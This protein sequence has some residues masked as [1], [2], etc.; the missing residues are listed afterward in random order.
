LIHGRETKGVIQLLN[1]LNDEPFTTVHQELLSDIAPSLALALDNANLYGGLNERLSELAAIQKITEAINS[2]TDIASL[3][4]RVA[5]E[6]QILIGANMTNIYQY[7][8]E[9]GEFFLQMEDNERYS[10][11]KPGGRSERILKEGQ[12]IF[13]DDVSNH[14]ILKESEFRKQHNIKAT[15]VAPLRAGDESVGL[16]FLNFE[17]QRVFS[18]DEKRIIA[19]IA[20]QAATAIQTVGRLNDTNRQLKTVL[21]S[22]EAAGNSKSLEELLNTYLAFSLREVGA[23]NGT[24][25][26]I[27]ASHGAGLCLA[28]R[29]Y[30][31]KL[32]ET[33]KNQKIPLEQGLTGYALRLEKPKYAPQVEK[34][35]QYVA[36][37]EGISTQFAV[38]L[39]INHKPLG[40]ITAE[41]GRVNAFDVYKRRL[42]ERFAG[43]A[44]I[45]IDQ[46]LQLQEEAKRRIEAE[47]EAQSAKMTESMSQA[48]AHHVKN[49][50]GSAR[51]YIQRVIKRSAEL[52]NEQRQE[53]QDADKSIN[54]CITMTQALLQPFVVV[55]K[56][57]VSPLLL[58][59][60][61][62]SDLG[63][64]PEDV[65]IINSV[66]ANL[67]EVNVVGNHATHY[68]QEILLNAT[69][70]VR[71]GIQRR[72]ITTG[73]IEVLG[74]A[75]RNN[76]VE[77]LF[78]NNG[79]PIPQ[80]HWEKIFEQFISYSD[81]DMAETGIRNLV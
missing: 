80:E 58:I 41:S 39:M 67:P 45:L 10:L 71:R 30:V 81:G 52:S 8:Q 62:I 25:Q 49:D 55:E 28:V 78:I 70:A 26:L 11:P 76:T 22:I 69:K 34:E 13:A 75:S 47:L 32:K 35:P 65:K 63:N 77:L 23:E 60:Q 6:A 40:V 29:A 38:P 59:S 50:L 31:G 51:W 1:R 9:Y 54:R 68:F 27:E 61:A 4:R 66:E 17:K 37:F 57:R 36:F 74:Q 2:E 46:R 16:L 21:Q 24:L 18:T 64:I 53:L 12:I 44:S 14:E 43:Q 42:F 33:F 72:M 19:I 3:L 5:Y 79:I 20:A 7:D 56:K 73:Y 48:L 15:I